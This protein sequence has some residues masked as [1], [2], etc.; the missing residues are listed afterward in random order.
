LNVSK[1]K[2]EPSRLFFL[3]TGMFSSDSNDRVFQLM[4]EYTE[5]ELMGEIF[6]AFGVRDEQ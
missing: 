4:K 2:K 1:K 3:C 6:L 5:M